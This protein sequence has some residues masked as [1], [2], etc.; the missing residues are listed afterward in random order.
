M[1]A[2]DEQIAAASAH[3]APKASVS[4]TVPRPMTPSGTAKTK[5]VAPV[6]AAT[7]IHRES[8]EEKNQS[9]AHAMSA[10]FPLI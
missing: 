3:V 2:S 10:G 9:M 8:L 1:P 5:N 7:R 6:V 4:A